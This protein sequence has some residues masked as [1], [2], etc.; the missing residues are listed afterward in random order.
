M[1]TVLYQDATSAIRLSICNP[2]VGSVGRTNTLL[3]LTGYKM[4]MSATQSYNIAWLIHYMCLLSV[5][6]PCHTLTD[7]HLWVSFCL[8]YK[9]GKGK[10]KRKNDD[11]HSSNARR[12][13]AHIFCL[14]WSTDTQQ[15]ILELFMPWGSQCF[16]SFCCCHHESQNKHLI[17]AEFYFNFVNISPIAFNVFY[18]GLH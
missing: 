14:L 18:V 6:V 13:N 11:N 7:I 2:A 12:T 4:T 10:N 17:F 1:N 3:G 15:K 9:Q 16:R 8:L 5:R